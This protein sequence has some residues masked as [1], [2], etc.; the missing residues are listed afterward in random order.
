MKHIFVMLGIS[1]ALSCSAGRDKSISLDA[2]QT[3]YQ[4][5]VVGSIISEKEMNDKYSVVLDDKTYKASEFEK[6]TD[7]ISTEY[8]LKTIQDN[9]KKIIKIVRLDKS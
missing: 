6:I 5:E 1:L 9:G 8:G 4:N 3:P 7:T 2:Q